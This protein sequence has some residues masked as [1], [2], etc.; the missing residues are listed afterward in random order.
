MLAKATTAFCHPTRAVS[1][2]THCEIRSLRLWALIT[3]DLAA[4]ISKVR[5]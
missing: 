1:C 4:W 2:T 5:S 3:A